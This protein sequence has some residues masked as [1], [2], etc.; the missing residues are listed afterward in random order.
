MWFSK[1]CTCK[2]SQFIG[3]C[4]VSRGRLFETPWS[5]A[6]QV[7]P[8]STMSWS[9]LKLM[10]VESVSHAT[11]LFSV[12]PFSCLQSFTASGS[13]PISW[14]FKSGGQSGFSISPSN[15]YSG[16]ILFR[17]DRFDLLAVQGTIKNL[18]QHHSLKASILQ[19]SA[20]FKVQLSHLY[21]TMGKTIGLTIQTFVGKVIS[22]LLNM[23][24]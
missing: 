12:V 5:A 18:L 16:V 15:A 8:S 10:S 20:F 1:Y 4:W 11:F 9:L 13:L 21:K 2:R 3:F 23:I 6:H 22:L 14:L 7:S 17:I 19:H 24:V